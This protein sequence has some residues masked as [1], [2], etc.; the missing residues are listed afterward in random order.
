M[1]GDDGQ[2]S[3][4]DFEGFL[5]PP[6]PGAGGTSTP[7]EERARQQALSEPDRDPNE[8]RE[9]YGLKKLGDEALLDWL[10]D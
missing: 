8:I 7:A 3:A 1:T 10:A 2:F 9:I 4:G 5:P 6:A